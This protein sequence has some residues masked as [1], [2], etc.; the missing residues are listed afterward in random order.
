MN[1]ARKTAAGLVVA[2]AGLLGFIAHWEG[3]REQVYLDI[4]GVPT[5]CEGHT[6]PE[7]KLGDRWT[8]PQCDA[9]LVKNVD[10]FSDAVLGCVQVPINQHQYDAFVALAFNVGSNAF[11]GSTLVRLANAGD[12]AGACK[13]ILRWNRAG[14]RVVKGLAN[15]RQAEY[16]L[17]I[18]PMPRAPAANDPTMRAAA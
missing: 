14:G 10:R 5:V 3:S 1:A 11:C 6:G 7:V 4:V 12:V 13:Q 9:I 15:R 8:K 2:S 17:C 16:E 18:K